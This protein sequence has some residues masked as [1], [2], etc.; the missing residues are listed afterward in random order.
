MYASKPGGGGVTSRANAN[1]DCL[2]N[3]GGAYC[4]AD[5]LRNMPDDVDSNDDWR[6]NIFRLGAISG[7]LSG[8][9]KSIGHSSKLI[10]R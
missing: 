9:E 6:W 4:K 8:D 7:V 3:P 5:C 10:D 1:L 2:G